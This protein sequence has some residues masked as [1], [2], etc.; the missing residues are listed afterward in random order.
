MAVRGSVPPTSSL[1]LT[2]AW[3]AIVSLCPGSGHVHSVHT[4]LTRA[5][6][7]LEATLCAPTR[8]A[9]P[10]PLTAEL[11]RREYEEGTGSGGNS[12]GG[13]TGMLHLAC[14]NCVAATLLSLSSDKL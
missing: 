4:L 9:R 1:V 3:V 6:P 13:A 2:R 7:E 8:G 11:L 5:L 12:S 10:L 14:P